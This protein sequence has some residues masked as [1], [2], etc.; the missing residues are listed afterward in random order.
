MCVYTSITN[1]GILSIK[2]GGEGWTIFSAVSNKWQLEVVSNFENEGL[3]F[4]PYANF[5]VLWFVMW[6]FSKKSLGK[7]PGC[8]SSIFS[9]VQGKDWVLA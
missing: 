5:I 7:V 1:F 9:G 6:E 4:C 2:E 8:T 3:R